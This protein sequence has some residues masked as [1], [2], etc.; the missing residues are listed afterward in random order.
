M[1][2]KPSEQAIN[3]PIQ[4]RT[5]TQGW[6]GQCGTG[7]PVQQVFAQTALQPGRGLPA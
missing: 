5:M 2:G 4:I 3:Q 7:N 1:A 6:Q